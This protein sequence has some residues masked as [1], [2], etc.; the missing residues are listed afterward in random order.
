MIRAFLTR[1]RTE[2]AYKAQLQYYNDWIERAR[3][4]HKSI[5]HIE[6]ARQAFVHGALRSARDHARDVP[7]QAGGRAHG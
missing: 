6:A 7:R 4:E 1:W 3:K 2:R 5:R